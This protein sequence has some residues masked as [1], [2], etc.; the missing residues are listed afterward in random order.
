MA[1]FYHHM[2]IRLT[3]AES[4]ASQYLLTLDAGSPGALIAP[5]VIDAR[6]FT[7]DQAGAPADLLALLRDRQ[8]GDEQLVWLGGI[9]GDVLLPAPFRRRF[10]EKLRLGE[11]VG[12]LRLVLQIEPSELCALPWEYLFVAQA[13]APDYLT[14]FLALHPKV[15]LVRRVS[16]TPN[17]SLPPQPRFRLVAGGG[18]A[19]CRAIAEAC[20]A[21]GRVRLD[22]L[23]LE[24]CSAVAL[25]AALREPAAVVHLSGMAL[26]AGAN[27]AGPLA[28][29]LAR[30]GVRL[31]VL[32]PPE[33]AGQASP[34]EIHAAAQVLLRAGIPAVVVGADPLPEDGAAFMAQALYRSI[35]AGQSLDDAVSTARLALFNPA[36]PAGAE[37]GAFTLYLSSGVETLFPTTD[38]SLVTVIQTIGTVEG[39]VIGVEGNIGGGGAAQPA[40]RN[41][42]HLRPT[43]LV[44]PLIGRDAALAAMDERLRQ[45]GKCYLCGAF[46]VG[47][48]SFTTELFDRL[49]SG[50]PFSDGTVWLNAAHMGAERLLEEIAGMFG[51]LRVAEADG[52]SG[53]I[54]ALRALLAERPQVLIALDDLDDRDAAHAL[55]EAAGD[56]VVILNGGDRIDLRGLAHSVELEPLSAEDAARLFIVEAL[57]D[58]PELAARELTQIDAICARLRYLPLAIRLVARRVHPPRRRPV[59]QLLDQLLLQIERRPETVLGHGDAGVAPI[60]TDSFARLQRQSG[61]AVRMLVRLASCPDYE[62]PEAVILDGLSEDDKFSAPDYL[63]E[64]FLVDSVGNGRLVLHPLLGALVKRQA[65]ARLRGQER[66]YTERWL[67]DYARAH[68]GDYGALAEEHRNLLGLLRAF[69]EDGRWDEAAPLMRRLFD[70][71]RVRGLWSL[72]LEHLDALASAA[73][74][75]DGLSE[76]GWIFLQRGTIAMLQSRFSDAANDFD[77]SDTAFVEACD[78][79]GQG[80][81]RARRAGIAALHGALTQAAEMLRE[82][83]ESMGDIAREQDRAEAHV[84]LASILATQ[85][86]RAAAQEQYRSALLLASP[87]GKLRANLALGRLARQAGEWADALAH[88]NEALWL[89]T[90]LGHQLAQVNVQ[91]EL[92]HLA[93]FQQRHDDAEA[94]FAEAQRGYEQLAYRP[95]VAQIRHAFGNL[96]LSRGDLDQAERC[97]REALAINEA[98]GIATNLA[99]NRYM[100]G[101]VAQRRGNDAAAGVHY[102]QA[103]QAAERAETRDVQLLA[104]SLFQQAKLAVMQEQYAEAC[105]L[106]ERAAVLAEQGRDSH[107]QTAVA[108][109]QKLIALQQQAG[110]TDQ[111]RDPGQEDAMFEEALRLVKEG[112]LILGA[113]VLSAPED[114]PTINLGALD[115]VKEGELARV[116]TAPRGSLAAA[117]RRASLADVVKEGLR[118]DIIKEGALDLV[119]ECEPYDVEGDE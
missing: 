10:R 74:E 52:R 46:G 55:L 9:L 30:A 26:G 29:A 73:T 23:L 27:V 19:Q 64:H 20:Q 91:Q 25:Q 56:C 102:L 81:V 87:E 22:P 54:N 119:A 68:E 41:V 118:E 51:D 79:A 116:R 39:T 49:T 34:P 15:S 117:L 3:A 43:S 17:V 57:L 114:A 21:P 88:Y 95:G 28:A 35:V 53:K 62:A 94:H 42:P 84:A 115:L 92:G 44:A 98:L 100:L 7:V 76:R 70:Y 13:D 36:H 101:V 72:A 40:A 96:A 18:A 32:G 67:L 105:V 4:V 33:Q 48:T 80:A 24:D 104:A 69:A 50:Q 108:V 66:R 2:Q 109:L 58:Q 99:Y 86:E 37:W 59:P 47:K 113:G 83:L 12:G 16:G 11:R 63:H 97:Y 5:A 107:T 75:V 31:V 89:A 8:I 6:T 45:G 14:D 60:F 90:Q 78:S 65:P 103:Q 61:A 71:L 38:A 110:A 93:Y 112:G 1:N 111:Q 85:G 82:G 77:R 106:L